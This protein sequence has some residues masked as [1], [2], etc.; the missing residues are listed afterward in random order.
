MCNK[1]TAVPDTISGAAVFLFIRI[2]RRQ[3][4]PAFRSHTHP[5]CKIPQKA[6][7]EYEVRN[8]LQSYKSVVG[9][10]YVS[11]ETNEAAE[12]I[13]IRSKIQCIPDIS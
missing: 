12:H 2:L 6:L 11:L 9:T 1:E 4:V 13:W 5:G 8:I 10:F 3:D 7:F